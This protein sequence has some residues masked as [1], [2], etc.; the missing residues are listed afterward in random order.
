MSALHTLLALAFPALVIVA[1]LKDLTSFTIPNWISI[2]LACAFV[3]TAMTGIMTGAMTW[4]E[5]GLHFAVGAGAL[6]AGMLMFAM[7]WIGGGDAKLF[8]ASGLWIGTAAFLPYLL[9]TA[10]A[11]GALAVLLVLFRHSYVRA[12]MPAGPAWVERLREPKGNAPYG[13]AIAIGA[14]VAGPL[15]NMGLFTLG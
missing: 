15:A 14:L 7:G 10:L 9:V 13:V 12:V 8:A 4:P 6:V 2:A 11:G 1:A 3:P 5:F